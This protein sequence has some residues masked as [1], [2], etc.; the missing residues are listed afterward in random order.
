MWVCKQKYLSVPSMELLHLHTNLEKKINTDDDDNQAP[1]AYNQI[2][3][4][5][6]IGVY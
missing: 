1:V 3:C 2:K 5:V 6:S 4:H